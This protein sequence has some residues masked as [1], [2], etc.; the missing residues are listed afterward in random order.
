MTAVRCK[1]LING[2]ENRGVLLPNNLEI[3]STADVFYEVL[4]GGEATGGTWTD[5]DPNSIAQINNSP[6]GYVGG[7]VIKGGYI[8]TSGGRG[9]GSLISSFPGDLFVSIDS[10]LGTQ[11]SVA[12][13]ATRLGSSTQARVELG[14]REIY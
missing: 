13:R 5:V 11:N 10:L 9:G 1:D 7:R 2:I 3:L 12:I 8:A 6:T 14:W 4:V